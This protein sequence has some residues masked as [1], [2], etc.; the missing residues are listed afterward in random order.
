ME[1]LGLPAVLLMGLAFGAGPCNLTCLPYLGPVFL[2]GEAGRMPWRTVLPFSAG[3]LTSYA[4]LGL[5]AGWLGEQLSGLL[6]SPVAGWILG[7]GTILIGLRLFWPGRQRACQGS[8][9]PAIQPV[10]I[11]RGRIELSRIGLFGMG[12]GMALNPCAPLTAVL[13][14]AAASGHGSSGLALG[15]AFGFGAIV[16]PSLLFGFGVARFG[17]ALR[18]QLADMK[19]PLERYAGAALL[20]VGTA[21]TLGWIRP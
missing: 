20:I 14:A 15:F 6:S 3:R 18:A 1:A 4:L 17:S 11:H 16:I 19:Q 13:V 12:A 5:L 21:T 7:G 9:T 8:A 10:R 2:A